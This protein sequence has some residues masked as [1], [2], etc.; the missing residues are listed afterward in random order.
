MHTP[1]LII[2]TFHSY[3]I[4][5]D[6]L[7]NHYIYINILQKYIFRFISN[8]SQLFPHVHIF[9]EIRFTKNS[10]WLPIHYSLIPFIFA[11]KRYPTQSS[12]LTP[13]TLIHSLEPVK[14]SFETFTANSYPLLFM[15]LKKTSINL[16]F[17]FEYL[18]QYLFIF[19]VY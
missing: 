1:L 15:E 12:S 18:Y 17:F 7:N 19:L 4:I 5:Y 11:S 8:T 16:S 3:Y 6:I 13:S 10:V 2:C 14:H 9:Y